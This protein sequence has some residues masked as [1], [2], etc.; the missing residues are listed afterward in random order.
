MQALVDTGS[1]HTL[2]KKSVV[3]RQGG[4]INTMKETPNLA[5]VTGTPLRIVGMAWLEI[6]IGEEKIYKQWFPVVP[7]SYLDSDVLLGC[8]VLGQAS[9]T[10]NQSNR[11]MLW[12]NATYP[13]SRVTKK[14]GKV[15]RVQ[16]LAARENQK[17]KPHNQLRVRK[18]LVIPPYQSHLYP[19]EVKAAKG[20]TIMVYPHHG[21]SNLNYPYISTVNEENKIICLIENKCRSN[22]ILKV[23]TL[24]GTYEQVIPD[25]NNV[26]ST[27]VIQND[28]LPHS[29]QPRRR[30][31]RRDKLRALLDKQDWNHLSKEQQ[32][33]LAEVIQEHHLTFILEKNE[34]GCIQSSPVN[35]G[36]RDPT[37]VRKPAYRYLEKAKEIIADL[38]Q[39]MEARDI[40]EPSTAAWLS[41][42]VLVTKPDGSKRMCLDYREVNSHLTTDIYPLPR[43]EELVETAS[44]N[45]YYATL[46][47]KDACFQVMLDEESRDVNAFSDGVSL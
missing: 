38:L 35:I 18:R 40:I 11:L 15:E 29:D 23:G 33:L 30:G 9:L 43:L 19:L 34:L 22:R 2:V 24:L 8:D 20:K 32:Q 45:K 36:I 14:P 41:P 1:G 13:V 12:G 26:K 39:D 25:S 21:I 27:T 3:E 46:D 16:S 42:I 10:W 4:E 28:L 31:D 44:G 17:D 6:A 5:G 47:L 37:P 7:D